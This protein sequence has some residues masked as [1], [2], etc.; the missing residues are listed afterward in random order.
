MFDREREEAIRKARIKFAVN[1]FAIKFK[2]WSQKKRK[3]M[4]GRAQ[5]SAR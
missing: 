1:M 3:T 2:L 5:V 4:D